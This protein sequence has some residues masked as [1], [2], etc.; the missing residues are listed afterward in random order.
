MQKRQTDSRY[1][2]TWRYSTVT[3]QSSYSAP[4]PPSRWHVTPM[5]STKTLCCSSSISLRRNRSKSLSTHAHVSPDQMEN[6]KKVN[7]SSTVKSHTTF[8][9]HTQP[10]DIISKVDMHTMNFRQPTDL[11]AVKHLQAPWTKALRSRPVYDEYC[12]KRIYRRT[13]TAA[14]TE[15][16]KLLG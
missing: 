5:K 14:Q 12:L 1:S 8:L 16:S 7:L 13:E 2:E 15:C 6:I 9:K 4:Y 11:G 3:T 10:K